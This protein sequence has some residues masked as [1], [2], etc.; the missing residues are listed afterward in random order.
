MECPSR[1]VGDPGEDLRVFVSGVIVGDGMDDLSCGDSS[2][3]RVQEL[4][5]LLMSMLF[6]AAPYD[7]SIQDVE[8]SEQRG[9]A[10]SFVI[11]GHGSA[12]SGL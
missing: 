8:C 12:F 1:M 6:Y 9:R 10:V 3:D 4:Y 7:G 5:E 2:F 11:V